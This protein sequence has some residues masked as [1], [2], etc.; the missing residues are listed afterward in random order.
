LHGIEHCRALIELVVRDAVVESLAPLRALR[1]LEELTI[2]GVPDKKPS[3]PLDLND[4]AELGAN[5]R[6]LRL[7][8]TGRLLNSSVIQSFHNL[9][10]TTL[11]F[12]NEIL[13]DR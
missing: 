8:N 1:Y 5:L 11:T 12:P 13:K 3:Q 9:Q 2:T 4:I 7:P 10:S 6:I